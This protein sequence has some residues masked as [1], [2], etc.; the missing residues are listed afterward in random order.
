M[1]LYL[2]PYTQKK[3]YYFFFQILRSLFTILSQIVSVVEGREKQLI[4]ILLLQTKETQDCLLY[5]R[6]FRRY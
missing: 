3:M 6:T 5:C 2:I 1:T 4:F